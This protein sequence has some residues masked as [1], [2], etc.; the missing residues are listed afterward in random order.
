VPDSHRIDGATGQAL[1]RA[2]EPISS[3]ARSLAARQLVERCT[4][5]GPCDAEHGGGRVGYTCATSLLTPSDRLRDQPFLLRI[6]SSLRDPVMGREAALG[7]REHDSSR[8]GV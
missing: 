4:A 5:D 6:T 8:S 7:E 2:W 1:L 3:Q